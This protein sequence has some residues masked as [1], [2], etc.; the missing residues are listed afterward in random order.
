MDKKIMFAIIAVVIVAIAAVA[1][2]MVLNKSESEDHSSVSFDDTRLRIYG[3]ANGDDVI[4]KTDVSIV[5]WI[6]SS[7]TDNDSTND[8]NW[9]T[10]YPLADANYDGKV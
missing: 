10:T 3:N 1:V 4:D 8:V 9:K 6:V 7:N 5:K 2:F